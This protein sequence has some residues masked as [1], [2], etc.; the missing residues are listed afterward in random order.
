[1]DDN[2]LKVL[3]DVGYT[4]PKVCGLCKYANISWGGSPL[5]GT[6]DIVT[7]Q[8]IKH[9]EVRELSISEYGS[10]PKWDGADNK[11]AR[12]HSYDEFVDT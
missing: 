11:I 6:C 8:H 10:C 5:W 2:K 7:Y 3:R 12:L 9:N 4:I 1:M